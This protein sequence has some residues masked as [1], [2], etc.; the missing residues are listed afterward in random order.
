MGGTLAVLAPFAFALVATIAIEVPLARILFGLCDPRSLTIVAL[1]QVVTNPWVEL[2]CLT[3]GF[4]PA[5]FP[6]PA[7]A[8]MTVA[9]LA[10]VVAEAAVYRACRITSRPWAMSCALNATSFLAGIA[11]SLVRQA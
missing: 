6:S 2:V 1:A 11:L 10:A 7:W 3:V 4:D 5:I 9:E 8:A